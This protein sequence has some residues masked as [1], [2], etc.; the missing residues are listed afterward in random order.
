MIS[1][2]YGKLYVLRD[3]EKCLR[4]MAERGMI[5]GKSKEDLGQIKSHFPLSKHVREVS[6]MSKRM[7]TI[8]FV[9][10]VLAISVWCV[11]MSE[12]DMVYDGLIS[13]WTFDEGDIDGQIVMDVA[14][15]NNG[16]MIGQPEIV[17]GWIGDALQFD[18]E[19]S[20]VNC[21]ADESLNMGKEDF[22][23]DAWFNAG[24]QTS[25]WPCL[26]RKGNALCDGCPPG[27]AIYWAGNIWNFALDNSNQLNDRDRVSVGSGPYMDEKWHHIAA[28]RDE[29]EIRL[30]LDGVLVASAPSND[31]NVNVGTELYL[32]F[33][34]SFN[35]AIDEA[36]IYNRALSEEEIQRNFKATSREA[37]VESAGKLATKWGDIK[38]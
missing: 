18:G 6:R 15:N 1:R 24:T 23:L 27:Y 11:G 2:Y 16:T 31:R 19:T 34:T 35:G 32:S 13:L 21:G 22:T 30:Y 10:A 26:F 12:A 36:K 7:S 37:A 38:K 9:L 28:T 25:S 8:A 4:K 14:G 17:D 3:V 20:G 29:S 5:I 33:D